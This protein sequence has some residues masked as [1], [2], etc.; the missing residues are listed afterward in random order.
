MNALDAHLSD[1][2]P[3]KPLVLSFHGAS[4][5]GKTFL[6]SLIIKALFDKGLKSKYIKKYSAT[7]HF[8]TAEEVALYKVRS[9]LM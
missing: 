5:S 9:D 3:K 8:P 2:D 4:G 7:L 6:S 1:D